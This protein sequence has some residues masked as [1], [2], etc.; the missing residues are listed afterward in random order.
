MIVDDVA[1][2]M[3]ISLHQI[4]VNREE[5]AARLKEQLNLRVDR[6]TVGYWLSK[7]SPPSSRPKRKGK[8]T[9]S[10]DPRK[11]RQRLVAQLLQRRA[12]VV[13]TDHT[14]IR[15]KLKTR[16]LVRQPFNSPAKIARQL[17]IEFN[18]K[19]SLSTVRRDLISQGRR[20]RR[21]RKTVYLTPKHKKARVHFAREAL[22]K[23]LRKVVF[24]DEKVFDSNCLTNEFQW[25]AHG[26]QVDG[27]P[28][29][30]AA[31]SVLCWAAIADDG[32]RIVRCIQ[33]QNLDRQRYLA[34]LK[35]A[36]QELR[37]LSARGYQF[38]QDNARPHCGSEAWLKKNKIVV[39]PL[40]WPA[41]SCD[42]SPIEQFWDIVNRR[43]KERGP[44]GAAELARYI[45]EEG[46][47]VPVNTVQRLASSFA[48][49]LQ[50]VIKAKGEMIKP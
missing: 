22:R 12:V 39:L 34:I 45:A 40:K 8:R 43:V 23:K 17:M 35:S 25:V 27:A 14:P 24:T 42:L 10:D 33:R 3:I 28:Q 29:E 44:F 48:G 16:T 36:S 1:Y 32:T 19:A 47:A 2:G 46:A 11:Q 26:E 4:G 50:K 6:R 9:K 21:K 38:Q 37:Q 18:I 30:R 13:G 7:N 20:P 49:R 41:L 31:P 5:I 15:R